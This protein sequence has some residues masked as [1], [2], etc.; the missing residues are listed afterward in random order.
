Y[1]KL[2]IAT[3]SRAFVPPMD[4]ANLDGVF[5]FRTL[6]DCAAMAAWTDKSA[7]ETNATN[8]PQRSAAVIGGGLLGLEAARGLLNRGLAVHVIDIN[9]HFM[10]VQLDPSGGAM[11]RK[12]IL[13]LGVTAHLEQ[14][15]AAL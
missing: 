4:G 12:A 14:R 8:A 5:V 11:L 7:S 2:I 15:P 3:G 13:N 1:D 9:P 10:S 6:D